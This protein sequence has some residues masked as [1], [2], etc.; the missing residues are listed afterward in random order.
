MGRLQ[1][2]PIVKK[3]LGGR[4][5]GDNDAIGLELEEDDFPSGS[6]TL[7]VGDLQVQA[8]SLEPSPNRLRWPL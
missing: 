2:D 3:P 6:P 4:I 7:V 5:A 1:L 8:A